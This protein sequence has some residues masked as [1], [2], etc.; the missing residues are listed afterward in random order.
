MSSQHLSPYDDEGT[1]YDDNVIIKSI[2]EPLT[3]T[4][5]GISL[6][7]S[8]TIILT[9]I[10]FPIMLRKKPF[11]QMFLIIA[12]TDF[13]SNIVVLFGFAHGELCIVQGKIFCCLISSS[14]LS[15]TITR[16]TVHILQ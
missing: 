4:I 14:S 1:F 5:A 3:Q 7:C 9:A 16:S 15:I 11:M 2:M 12:I 6:L 10:V 8:F 13:V